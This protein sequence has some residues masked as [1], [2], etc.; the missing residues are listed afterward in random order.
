MKTEKIEIAKV[1][2]ERDRAAIELLTPEERAS[3]LVAAGRKRQ[4]A[5]K[6]SLKEEQIERLKRG[7]IEPQIKTKKGDAYPETGKTVVIGGRSF[8]C[9]GML[10]EYDSMAVLKRESDGELLVIESFKVGNWLIR[11]GNTE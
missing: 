8:V 6:E 7:E 3:I 10:P 2:N 9:L 1:T 5:I 4:L 11:Q